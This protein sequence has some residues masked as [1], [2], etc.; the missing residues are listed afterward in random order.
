MEVWFSVRKSSFIR[1]QVML[2]VF[3]LFFF[4]F[5]EIET[6]VLFLYKFHMTWFSWF[7][8][9]RFLFQPRLFSYATYFFF[10][11]ILFKQVRTILSQFGNF[12]SLR[13][14]LLVLQGGLLLSSLRLDNST[15]FASRLRS[16]LKF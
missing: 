3:L 1:V 15:K 2:I 11:K 5:N 10:H 9:S 4:F 6:N 7:V 8:S 16:W 14:D 13:L 12:I